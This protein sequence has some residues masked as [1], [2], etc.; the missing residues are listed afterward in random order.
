[1]LTSV[2]LRNRLREATGLK[3][4]ATLVFD[5]PTPVAIARYLRDELG[6]TVASAP[7]AAAVVAAPDEPI[8]IVG[9]ACRLPGGVADPEG[10][11]RL[12]RE[13]REGLSPFPEDRGWD[14]ENLFD[15]DPDS[16]GTTYTSQGGFLEGAGLFD[17]AF[18][19]ISP[20]EALAMDPQ[21]RL[22]L[23]TS[24]EAMEDAGVDP[25]SLK[26]ND[27]GVFTGMFGQGYVAPGASVVTPE[28]EGF[29]GT[30]GSSSVASG[31]VSYVFGFEGPVVTIDSACS[32][33]L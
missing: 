10:L 21:Q 3:L 32:S 9:M 13:G 27:V 33:S 18:F 5:Y 14:L 11:W 17:A 2:E 22:L 25:L 7:A 6:D 1:S 15:S 4:P 26:G 19:G 29:A 31:R 23:E 12:V 8:A 24:W 20:R 28:L 30:G 16:S